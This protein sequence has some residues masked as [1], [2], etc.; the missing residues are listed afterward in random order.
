VR[1]LIRIRDA[2]AGQQRLAT[3]GTVLPHLVQLELPVLG[4]RGS[5]AFLQALARCPSL[6]RLAL[7]QPHGS[8]GQEAEPATLQLLASTVSPLTQ[9]REL[10]IEWTSISP[11]VEGTSLTALLRA[12]PPSLEDM[13]MQHVEC[14]DTIP[15]S[16]MTHLV[17]LRAWDTPI[18][19][20]VELDSSSSSGGGG[21]GRNCDASALTAL[22][23]LRLGE[24]CLYSS[25]A[26][27]QLP[28]LR[29]LRLQEAHP[30]AWEQLWGMKQL[31]S[32]TVFCFVTSQ[33]ASND[34][35]V[36]LGGMTQLEQLQLDVWDTFNFL[37]PPLSQP[38][39]AAVADLTRLA[40]L[41]LPAHVLLVGGSDL[42]APLMQ[43]K[44]LTVDCQNDLD[45][46]Y[47]PEGAQGRAATPPGAVLEVVTAAVAGGKGL[48]LQQL[49]LVVSAQA[50]EWEGEEGSAWLVY[51]AA[52]AALPGL[53][54]D[55]EPR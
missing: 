28:N 33:Q 8:A 19:D 25:D 31:R 43:L 26:R 51:D 5:A 39:A 45:Q 24:E 50:D 14:M 37:L 16:C 1:L 40:V 17:N 23:R 35:R 55:V 2:L 10:C 27:L 32:L 4:L 54:V 22:T 6:Q 38:W 30:D 44:E 12:L 29:A 41:H 21:G 49:V 36:G 3:P 9:L 7:K 42:L 53:I 47:Y 15:L 34:Y 11:Y 18:V 48:L 52:R 13:E 46:Q 20:M